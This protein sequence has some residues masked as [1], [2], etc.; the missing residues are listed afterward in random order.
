[1]SKPFDVTSKFLIEQHPADWLAFAGWTADEVQ[2]IDA[3]L[4]SVT[5]AADKVLRVSGPPPWLGHV[6]AQASYEEDMAERFHSYSVLLRRRHRL[7][8]H[9]VVVLLR[10]EADG[11]AM[12]GELRYYRTDGA[13]YEWFSYQVVRVWETSVESLLTGGLGTLPLAAVERARL[14]EVIRRM[15]ARITE[16]VSAGE[17]KTFWMSTSLLMGLRYPFDFIGTL[18]QGVKNMDLRESSTYQAILAEGEAIGEAKGEAK[19]EANALLRL[20]GRRFGT[21]SATVRAAITTMIDVSRLNRLIDR[22]L[23]VESWDE[24]LAEE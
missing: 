10:P 11:Q 3:D 6:E 24:L 9:T 2:V 21:P 14:P 13:C 7:P 5:A 20:G 22:L 23:E 8:V 1:M 12:S 16:E 18:L 4:A 19:G 15:D 17:A